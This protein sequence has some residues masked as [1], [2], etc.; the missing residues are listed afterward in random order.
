MYPFVG[1]PQEQLVDWLTLSSTETVR[2]SLLFNAQ[3]HVA[4]DEKGVLVNL[5]I[6]QQN[7]G[8][9]FVL[10]CQA[11]LGVTHK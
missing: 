10:Q 2:F 6:V 5:G 9:C 1:I 7:S 4:T 11:V 3:H 8:W